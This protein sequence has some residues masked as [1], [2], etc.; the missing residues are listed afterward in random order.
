MWSNKTECVD[1]HH[2]SCGFGG[3]A[4]DALDPHEDVQDASANVNC[5][6]KYV[7]DDGAYLIALE[8]I[9]ANTELKTAYSKF[10]WETHM[11][12]GSLP[13]RVSAAVQQAYDL[14]P[15]VRTIPVFTHPRKREQR[16]K[17]RDEQVV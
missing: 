11:Q 1:A 2:S 6:I 16:D 15:A 9:P 17:Q 7:T 4:N 8:D 3:Y 12:A 13:P 5:T 10:Y 14:L